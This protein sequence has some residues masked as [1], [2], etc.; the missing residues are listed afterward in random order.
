V[1]AI[2]FDLDTELLKQHYH[3]SS[4]TNAYGDIADV[5]QKHGFGRQQGSV[6]FGDDNTTPVT[7]VLAVQDVQKTH[8]WFRL[9]VSDI[10]MLRIEEN[11]DLSEALDAVGGPSGSGTSE[12]AE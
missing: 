4:Y 10:R 7:C 1:Y 3:N 2:C 11:N 12:A 5:L 8:H 9:V 6:Y